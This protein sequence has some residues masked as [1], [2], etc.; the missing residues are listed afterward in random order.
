MSCPNNMSQGSTNRRQRI[1]RIAGIPRAGRQVGR[2]QKTFQFEHW[3][4][5]TNRSQVLIDTVKFKN[6][7]RLK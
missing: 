6:T 1:T 4:V 2:K 7:A 5:A 3:L